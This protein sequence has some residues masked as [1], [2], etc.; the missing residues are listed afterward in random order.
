MV[1]SANPSSQAIVKFKVTIL[2]RKWEKDTNN[3]GI[4]GLQK[5]LSPQKDT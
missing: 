4:L 5:E 2:G 1:N 3:A